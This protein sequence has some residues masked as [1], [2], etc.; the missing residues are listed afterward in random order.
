MGNWFPKNAQK[1]C[2]ATEE[3]WSIFWVHAL[4]L[5]H[6]HIITSQFA[7][8]A[9]L[10]TRTKALKSRQVSRVIKM[11]SNPAAKLPIASLD[12]RNVP[13]SNS[14]L[15]GAR[16][17]RFVK[18]PIGTRTRANSS[19]RR[20]EKNTLERERE[21]NIYIYCIY[22]YIIIIIERDMCFVCAGFSSRKNISRTKSVETE[23]ASRLWASCFFTPNLNVRQKQ[24]N[25]CIRKKLVTDFGRYY[26]QLGIQFFLASVWL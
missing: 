14:L 9:Y 20:L 11:L 13:K 26:T 21:K 1:H 16:K 7:K 2:F 12:C 4:F 5:S 22:I 18:G 17:W 25:S 23:H 10:P 24:G 15:L 6:T 8:W 19:L 3:T